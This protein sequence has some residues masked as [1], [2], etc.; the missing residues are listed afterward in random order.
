[1]GVLTASIPSTKEIDDA[2]EEA[3]LS[4]IDCQNA[5][6]RVRSVTSHTS[7]IPRSK[8]RPTRAVQSLTNPNPIMV[9]PQKSVIVASHMRGPKKRVKMVVGGWAIT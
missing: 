7:R 5:M 3:T 8:R 2:W 9:T 1:M 6:P 4:Q